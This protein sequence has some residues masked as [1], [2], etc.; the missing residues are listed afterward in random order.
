MEN[1]MSLAQLKKTAKLAGL[2]Y[3]LLAASGMIGFMVFHP[4]IFI[5]DDPQK[6][7]ANLTSLSSD[8]NIR[9]LF[10]LVIIVSQSL[11]AVWFCK[12]FY[13]INKQSALAICFWG[14]VNA[15]VLTISAIS[16][17]SAIDIANSTSINTQEKVV[18]IKL[19]VSVISNAWSIGGLFFGLWLIPMGYAIVSSERMPVWLGRV[20]IAGGI[21]YLLQTF[22]NAAGIQSSYTGILV[23]PAT[24][25]ELWM[26]GY[27][28]SYGIRPSNN[29][30]TQ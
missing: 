27:L 1:D 22:I 15:V 14:T 30:I 4:K 17:V 13:E 10:E 9:L 24:I 12:L 11:A 16:M 29:N 6:T 5:D 8:S 25:G 19:L 28:L 23:I 7:L 21:G 18:L 3:L 2:W 26:I 20:L